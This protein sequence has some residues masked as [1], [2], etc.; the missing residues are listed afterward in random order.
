M[1]TS[2]RIVRAV[3]TGSITRPAA[4]VPVVATIHWHRGDVTE[5]EA[6]ALAWTTDAVEVEW[7]SHLGLRTDWI[8]AQQVRRPGEPARSTPEVRFRPGRK[9][10][11][12]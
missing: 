8:P 5:M 7:R 10:N 12:W 1:T 4:P 3:P 2:V 6:T 9:N 11:R